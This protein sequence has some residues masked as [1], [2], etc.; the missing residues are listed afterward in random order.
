MNIFGKEF[1]E[2]LKESIIVIVQNAV[3][4]L[5]ENNKEDQRYL[6]KKQAIRYVGGMNPQDFDL[7][8]QMG[9]KIIYL[10]RPNGKTSIRYD[11]QEIDVFMAKFKI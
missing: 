6:N 1:I 7:L 8:P 11:K 9:L 5:V 3:K 10:E 2:S 4:V